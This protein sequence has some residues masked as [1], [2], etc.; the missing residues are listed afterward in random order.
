MNLTEVL[1]SETGGTR[2]PAAVLAVRQ[3]DGDVDVVGV[4][5]S[6]DSRFGIGSVTKVMTATLVLQHVQRGDFKLDD[7]ISAFLPEFEVA[8]PSSTGSIT[9]E[10]LLTHTSGLD[11]AD[12]FVDTGA[13]ADCL[14]RFVHEVANGS[15]LLHQPGEFWGYSNGGY[16][17]LGRLIEVV[18]GRRWE[19]AIAAGVFAPLNLNASFAPRVRSERLERGHRF[20]TS[21]GTIVEE[22][23]WL[24]S[25]SGPAGSNLVATAEDLVTFARALVE[26]DGVLLDPELVTRMSKPVAIPHMTQQALG[27]KVPAPGVLAHS[28]TTLGSSAHLECR[29]SGRIVS[30]V[31][32]GPG[33]HL[34]AATVLSHLEGEPN[35]SDDGT[36]RDPVEAK[37]CVGTYR[38]RFAEQRIFLEGDKLMAES[39]HSGS[40]AEIHDDLPPVELQHAHG[41]V[42]TSQRDFEEGPSQWVFYRTGSGEPASH[43]L[44]GRRLHLRQP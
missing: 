31:A 18:E 33:A 44:T 11:I 14:E 5:T 24:P 22:S 12:A 38:R 7:P 37:M 28:G 3:P 6:R 29:P 19:D 34:M 30:V 42:Y 25:S 40:L 16:S 36:P 9:I 20:D 32:N 8:P 27:W 43:L 41:P 17:L 13:D 1:Q 4:N 15:S 35:Y 2:A 26:G 21:T 39:V 10:H 23:R